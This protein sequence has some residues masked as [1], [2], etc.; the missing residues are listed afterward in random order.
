MKLIFD[1]GFR[2]FRTLFFRKEEKIAADFFT[3]PLPDCQ[4][5]N[6]AVYLKN[7]QKF[8]P[9]L[10]KT[11]RFNEFQISAL[12]SPAFFDYTLFSGKG[13]KGSFIY[14]NP[15]HP[16]KMKLKITPEPGLLENF[17]L[18]L[19]EKKIEATFLGC[20]LT[21]ELDAALSLLSRPPFNRRKEEISLFLSIGHGCA[22]LFFLK[23]DC[24][25]Y[26]STNKDCGALHLDQEIL[27]HNPADPDKVNNFK[28]NELIFLPSFKKQTQN[29]VPAF[30]HCRSFFENLQL[31]ISEAVQ[32]F[33]KEYP[34]FK[35]AELFYSGG[36][37]AMRNFPVYLSQTIN[38]PVVSLI[39]AVFADT[40][41]VSHIL[42]AEF[43]SSA[44]CHGWKEKL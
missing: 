16:Q 6:Q 10:L 14:E 30:T 13:E 24:I 38:L 35:P 28:E 40:E 12:L 7:L 26:Y 37:G 23:K 43:Y 17:N 32:D 19:T 4:E 3:L 9:K 20:A 21:A 36:I 15:G 25:I 2:C 5:I 8:L 34:R 39:E 27:K 42:P 22:H 31:W 44:I 1:L 41:E 29:I 11:L 33:Q 18:L